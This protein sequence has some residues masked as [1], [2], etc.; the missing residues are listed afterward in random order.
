VA[1]IVRMVRDLNMNLEIVVV[2]TVREADGLAMSSRNSYLNAA[3]R[4]AAVVLYRALTAAREMR[5]DGCMDAAAVLRTMGEVIGAEPLAHLD[6]ADVVDPASFRKLE[7][8]E[9]PG[10]AVLAVRI[11]ATRLIDNMLLQG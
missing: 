9:T 6:Y 4:A 10:L 8:L 5:R 1:V 7:S 3:E 2:P 11:G